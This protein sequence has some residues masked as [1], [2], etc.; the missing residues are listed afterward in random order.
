MLPLEY[1]LMTILEFFILMQG[2]GVD[3]IMVLGY[4]VGLA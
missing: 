1:G 2:D 3:I 4:S